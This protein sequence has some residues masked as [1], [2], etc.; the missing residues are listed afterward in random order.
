MTENTIIAAKHAGGRPTDYRPEYCDD[1][2][3]WGKLGK[4]KAWMCASLDIA[5]TTLDLW[6][7][8][9]PEFSYAMDKALTNSQLWWEDAGQRGMETQGF[10]APIWSRSM[11][12]RFPNDW[13]EKSETT[14]TINK[15]SGWDEVFAQVSNKSRSL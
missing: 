12:A 13:R 5:R 10:S 3:E 15:G 1:V 9:H 14:S 11:G 6:I 7:E 2:I 4:S 8:T